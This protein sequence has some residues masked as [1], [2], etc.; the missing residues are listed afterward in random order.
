M[1]KLIKLQADVDFIKNNMVD[2]DYILDEDDREALRL[3]EEEYRNGETISHEEL[4]K[5][6]EL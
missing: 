2:I 1:K 4:K 6:L 5:E 3:A